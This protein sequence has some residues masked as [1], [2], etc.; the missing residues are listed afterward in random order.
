MKP[1]GGWISTERGEKRKPR[2]E[3]LEERPEG[4]EQEPGKSVTWEF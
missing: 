2:C 4:A 1:W 3:A